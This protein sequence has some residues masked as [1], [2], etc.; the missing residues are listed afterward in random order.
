MHHTT[1]NAAS[2]VGALAGARSSA[3]FGNSNELNMTSLAVKTNPDAASVQ[4]HPLCPQCR[5]RVATV[6]LE[7]DIVYFRA[8]CCD[9]C[10]AKWIAYAEHRLTRGG[11]TSM[12]GQ[13][14]DRIHVERSG[15]TREQTH[16]DAIDVAALT[17]AVLDGL[18]GDLEIPRAPAV[19][20]APDAQRVVADVLC[21]RLNRALTPSEIAVVNYFAHAETVR[22]FE[23][24]WKAKSEQGRVIIASS[25]LR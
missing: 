8:S 5:E 4:Q 25:V 19:L 16:I 7:A 22:R 23:A 20:P 2:L 15:P 1:T 12:I 17:V 10:A 13:W 6:W 21:G 3:A 18:T 9:A 14:D 24:Q 11:R